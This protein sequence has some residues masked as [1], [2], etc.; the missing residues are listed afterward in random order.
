[1]SRSLMHAPSPYT[2]RQEIVAQL[3]RTELLF[4]GMKLPYLTSQG[5]ATPY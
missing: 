3:S 2:P 4:S 5:F 1:M